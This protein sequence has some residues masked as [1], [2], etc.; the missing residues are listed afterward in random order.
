MKE[1]FLVID[2]NEIL[3]IL[4]LKC[5]TLLKLKEFSNK[6]YINE[7][8]KE[9]E[10]LNTILDG[11]S[12]NIKIEESEK[13]ELTKKTTEEIIENKIEENKIEENKIEENKIEL[14]TDG[15]I[16]FSPRNEN[17]MVTIELNN[18]TKDVIVEVEPEEI[19][20]DIDDADANKKCV[21]GCNFCVNGCDLICT[22]LGYICSCFGYYIGKI[23]RK[24][25]NA[26]IN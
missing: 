3:R 18:N 6:K 23:Y 7:V 19:N 15:N 24:I 12:N 26:L 17:K 9:N 16:I 13:K 25:K 22:G 4:Y 20:D 1:D 14:K 21:N 10:T 2:H 5:N 8:L 11:K